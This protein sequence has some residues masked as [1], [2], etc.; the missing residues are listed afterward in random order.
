MDDEL[1]DYRYLRALY[2]FWVLFLFVSV[3]LFGVVSN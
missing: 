3:L 1:E 2:R